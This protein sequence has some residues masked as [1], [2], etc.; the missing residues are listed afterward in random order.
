MPPK[1]YICDRCKQQFSSSTGLKNHSKR[2]KPCLTVEIPL[3][4]AIAEHVRLTNVLADAASA[5]TGS[6]KNEIKEEKKDQ[7]GELKKME[8]V[9]ANGLVAMAVQPR[10]Y[11]T[12]APPMDMSTVAYSNDITLKLDP[13]TGN[14]TV[15]FGSSKSGKSTTLMYLY[16]KYYVKT[17][18][19]LFTESPQIKLY[20][21]G[22][23]LIANDFY[24]KIV[25]DMHKINKRCKNKYEF[26]C[27]LDDIVTAKHNDTLRKMVLV[28]RN[29]K[30]SSVVSLQDCKL[31][32]KA[33]RGSVNNYIFMHFNTPE[34]IEEV[35][36]MFLMTHL[37]G[38]M[39]AKIRTYQML[40]SN[41]GMIYYNPRDDKVT[42]HRLVL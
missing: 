40:T 15:I 42:Y 32:S 8:A 2:K 19:V 1:L 18:S 35:I 7:G 41:H 31:L 17:I 22:K 36:R 23:L 16:H 39:E 20:R 14:S 21:A 4:Q 38:P 25:T 13:K 33:N 6:V 5:T 27:L 9:A 12:I 37:P 11:K 28:L 29:S 24:P 10:S 30:I 34:I 26:T 3:D